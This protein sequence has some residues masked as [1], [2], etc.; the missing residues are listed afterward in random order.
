MIM[1]YVPKVVKG[2]F[3]MKKFIIIGGLETPEQLDM[4][5]TIKY[6]FLGKKVEVIIV[7]DLQQLTKKIKNID[8]L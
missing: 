6:Q 5:R 1:N 3:N 8:S 4:L 7:K 2:Q